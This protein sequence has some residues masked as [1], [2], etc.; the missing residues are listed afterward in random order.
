MDSFRKPIRRIGYV[1]DSK[2][3][4]NHILPKKHVSETCRRRV[5]RSSLSWKNVRFVSTL[6]HDDCDWSERTL[7][8]IRHS[9]GELCQRLLKPC[10]QRAYTS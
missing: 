3:T 8:V 5:I 7:S 2:R 4:P 9:S 1:F 10:I 6:G